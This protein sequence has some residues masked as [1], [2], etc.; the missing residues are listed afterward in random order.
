MNAVQSVV[1]RVAAS[2]RG[3]WFFRVT[4]ID[5]QDRALR[6]I[7]GGRGT[8]TGVFAGFPTIFVTTRGRRSGDPHTVPLVGITD[9]ER[10]G[11]TCV[12]ASN[13]GQAHDPDWCRNLRARGEALVS[14]GGE[15]RA[16]RAAEVPPGQAYERWFTLGAGIYVGFP[17]YRERA[18]RHIPVF[19]LTPVE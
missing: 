11:V 12:I 1:Q 17:G 8:V 18:G 3:A 6:R 14:A 5:L 15:N 7:T 9:P 13:F 4:R 16:R 2:P 19:E 10:P